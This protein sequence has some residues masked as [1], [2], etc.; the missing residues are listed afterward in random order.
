MLDGKFKMKGRD[1]KWVAS[2]SK[3]S[4]LSCAL[5][6]RPAKRSTSIF[7]LLLL[8]L[9]LLPRPS[10]DFAFQSMTSYVGWHMVNS[11]GSKH[12]AQPASTWDK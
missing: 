8:L 9:L 3:E 12:S 11:I 7:R 4:N 10:R 1:I 5:Y 2:R 6:S